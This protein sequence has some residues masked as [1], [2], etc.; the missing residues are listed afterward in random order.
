MIRPGRRHG[1]RQR[2]GAAVTLAPDR[3]PVCDIAASPSRRSRAPCSAAGGGCW[4]P[5]RPPASSPWSGSWPRAPVG[6]AFPDC[7]FPGRRQGGLGLRV[8]CRDWGEFGDAR[9]VQSGG[10]RGAPCCRGTAR[11]RA[12][13]GGRA[14]TLLKGPPCPSTL[15][16]L[17]R[18]VPAGRG[19]PPS[20]SSVTA[21][22]S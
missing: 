22:F 7:V 6:G 1:P 10:R 8:A 15:K 11:A 21:R 3:P 5:F 16:V 9:C 12:G 13:A 2:G 4:G 20:S 17:P 18:L 14:D 19:L